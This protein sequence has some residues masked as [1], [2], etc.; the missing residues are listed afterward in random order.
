MSYL[1]AIWE[2]AVIIDYIFSDFQSVLISIRCTKNSG[3]QLSSSGGDYC[4]L[5]EKGCSLMLTSSSGIES[6]VVVV[7][8]SDVDE[9]YSRVPGQ[10]SFGTKLRSC[11]LS[12][13]RLS[14]TSS[15]WVL[16]PYLRLC[17]L[18]CCRCG[19][20][21]DR[22]SSISANGSSEEKNQVCD[23]YIAG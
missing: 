5:G 19:K 10:Y 1:K 2:N 17:N 11:N 21:A 9:G 13:A 12:D 14:L 22:L 18:D 16:R 15:H 3:W 23:D 8:L 20:V 6:V 4:W 7:L